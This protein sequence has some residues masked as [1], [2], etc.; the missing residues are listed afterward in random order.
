MFSIKAIRMFLGNWS[1]RINFRTKAIKTS[2][3]C[4]TKIE[5]QLFTHTYINY[6]V[7]LQVKN[8][9]CMT[10][11]RKLDFLFCTTQDVCSD[12]LR[13]KIYIRMC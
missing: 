11:V 10:Y 13:T 5:N 8:G 7:N 3:L 9:L 6:I 1:F 4:Y 12:R 2:I